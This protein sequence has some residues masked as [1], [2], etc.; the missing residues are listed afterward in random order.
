M[1]KAVA[2]FS[3]MAKMNNSIDTLLGALEGVRKTG[4][5]RWIAKCC[6]H[7]DR[8]PSLAIRLVDDERILLH[9]FAGC[10]VA[11]IVAAAGLQLEDLFPP[12][13]KNGDE[14]YKRVRQPFSPAD[15]LKCLIREST[16]CALAASDIINGRPISAS[17]YARI[18]LARERIFEATE[19][20]KID[21]KSTRTIL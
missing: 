11:A 19:W 17:D 6:A 5:D 3:G 7:D 16:I 8:S 18:D 15:V 21:L 20:A 9:C 4:H 13:T 2:S 12:R 1:M 10:D 14:G